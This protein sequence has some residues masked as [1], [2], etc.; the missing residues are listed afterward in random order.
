[1]NDVYP[2]ERSMLVAEGILQARYR[3]CPD[4]SCEQLLRP[5]EPALLAVDMGPISIVFN[6]G[7]RIRISITSSNAPSFSPNPNTG[8]IYLEA[9][10]AGQVAHT[11][12]LHDADHPSAVI[13]PVK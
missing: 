2:D 11:M 3:H 13:L 1:M 9:G 10:A 5:G 6:A 4:Y 12:I 8:D 7:H